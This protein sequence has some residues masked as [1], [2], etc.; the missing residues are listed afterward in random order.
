MLKKISDT[1]CSV[2]PSGI[3]STQ[4]KLINF[5]STSITFIYKLHF[6]WLFRIK[7]KVHI[8]FLWN[9]M[10]YCQFLLPVIQQLEAIVA[11]WISIFFCKLC[12]A[13]FADFCF[14]QYNCLQFVPLQIVASHIM[15]IPIR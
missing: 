6:P 10:L 9:N 11:Y 4:S 7:K 2:S 12:F 14:L 5:A 1:D 13:S 15:T 8:D 3:A